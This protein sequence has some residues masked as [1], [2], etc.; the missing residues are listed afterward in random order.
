MNTLTSRLPTVSEKRA[1]KPRTLRR[2]L[3]EER[4]LEISAQA[5]GM[6]ADFSALFLDSRSPE[7]LRECGL[8]NWCLSYSASAVHTAM[9]LVKYGAGAAS[10]GPRFHQL[11]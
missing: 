8:P 10:W 3:G 11:V 9:T 4:A 5:L 1:R 6:P 7:R 2:V